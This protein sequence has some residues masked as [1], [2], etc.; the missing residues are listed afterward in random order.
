MGV[1]NLASDKEIKSAFRKLAKKYHPD[2]NNNEG[3]KEKFA[4]IYTAYEILTDA[5]KRFNYD[6]LLKTDKD[7]SYIEV[8]RD[9]AHAFAAEFAEM[10]YNDFLNKQ[11]IIHIWSTNRA[12][13]TFIAI[14]N[15]I[16]GCIGLFA[17]IY[18]MGKIKEEPFA[19][20]P[21]SMGVIFLFG[22]FY[23]FIAFVINS[24]NNA[25]I[26]NEQESE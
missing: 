11:I 10:T 19:F 17:I 23:L 7:D 8:W 12:V 15:L 2:V 20:F 14:I 22:G 13:E 18:G 9:Q 16:L 3:A 4:D 24:I 25:S 5:D 26:R 21:M 1:S 6:Q